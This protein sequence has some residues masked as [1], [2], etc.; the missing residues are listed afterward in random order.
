MDCF[1]VSF[2]TSD[3]ASRTAVMAAISSLG[4]VQLTDHSYALTHTGTSQAL[5]NR[6]STLLHEGHLWVMQTWQRPELTYLA[7]RAMPEAA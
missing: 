1:I 5:F 4:A 3:A 7:A 2:D 6:L